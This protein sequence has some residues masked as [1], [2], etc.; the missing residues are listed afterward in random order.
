LAASVAAPL[1][2]G[3]DLII[4]SIRTIPAYPVPGQQ[5]DIQVVVKNQGTTDA[6]PAPPDIIITAVYIDLHHEPQLGDVD[7]GYTGISWLNAGKN[8]LITFKNHQFTDAGCAHDIWAWTDR[9][10]AVIEDI[11]INNKFDSGLRAQR[12]RRPPHRRCPT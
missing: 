5:F 1:D 11:E 12:Q 10:S 9:D 2:P 6:L 3:P 4:E 8:I 7:D